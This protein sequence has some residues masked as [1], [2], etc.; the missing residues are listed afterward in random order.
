MNEIEWSKY[1]AE[2]VYCMWF[3]TWAA[4]LKMYQPHT[5][6]LIFFARKLLQ[7]LTQKLQPMRE[8]EIIYRRMFEACGSCKQHEQVKELYKEM[9]T[10][11]YLDT[12][13]ITFGT[14]YQALLLSQHGS[15]G[16]VP[17]SEIKSYLPKEDIEAIENRQ[18]VEEEK[19]RT[20]QRNSNILP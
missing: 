17:D 18:K 13:K 10:L 16:K 4:T 12:D 2:V 5:S 3:H 15:D 8:V 9:K 1:M 7:Y 11:K 20:S 19:E 14:Y 6:E